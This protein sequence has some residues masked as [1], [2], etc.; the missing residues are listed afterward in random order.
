MARH[1]PTCTVAGTP[2]DS[3]AAAAARNAAARSPLSA[4]V[5]LSHAHTDVLMQDW[6]LLPFLTMLLSYDGWGPSN[7]RHTLDCSLLPLLGGQ[8]S[9]IIR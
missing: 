3:C 5:S 9:G 8:F 4:G 6:F 1:A 7:V 2:L